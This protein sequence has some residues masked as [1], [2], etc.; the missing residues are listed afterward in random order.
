MF[1]KGQKVTVSKK[2]N[3][4]EAVVVYS[5]PDMIVV[6]YIPEPKR[7]IFSKNCG[8]YREAFTRADLMEK[9]QDGIYYSS[10]VPVI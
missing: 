1:S 10:I 6:K 4:R 3:R 2:G 5:R 8:A 7:S 9:N